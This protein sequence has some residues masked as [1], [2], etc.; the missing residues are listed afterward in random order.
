MWVSD[1]GNL[2]F[3]LPRATIEFWHWID[4]TIHRVFIKTVWFSGCISLAITLHSEYWSTYQTCCCYILPTHV[5]YTAVYKEAPWQLFILKECTA[6]SCKPHINNVDTNVNMTCYYFSLSCHIK[7]TGFVL[8][9]SSTSTQQSVESCFTSNDL[10][11][12]YILEKV[13][14]HAM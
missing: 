10:L 9:T 7:R 6:H 12:W 4:D 3:A 13:Q 2:S 8:Q 11:N 14:H 1:L 5:Q